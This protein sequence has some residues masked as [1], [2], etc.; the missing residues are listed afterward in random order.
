MDRIGV[1]EF[2]DE[3][4]RKAL[5][6]SGAHHIIG[7]DQG[8][9]A[10]QQIIEIKN[11]GVFLA[12]PVELRD[13]IEGTRHLA[14]HSIANLA[15]QI[16]KPVHTGMEELVCLLAECRPVVFSIR[17]F[18]ATKIARLGERKR[19]PLHGGRARRIGKFPQ[20]GEG[21]FRLETVLVE[22]GERLE[23][24]DQCSGAA[25]LG[26]GCVPT[27]KCADALDK[28]DVLAQREIDRNCAG[29]G[30]RQLELGK[31]EAV[32]DD[33]QR[34]KLRE[35]SDGILPFLQA[36]REAVEQPA[37]D[38]PLEH[39]IRGGCIHHLRSGVEL[40]FDGVGHDDLLTKG[41]NR[42]RGHLVEGVNGR[43]EDI[44]FVVEQF[45]GDG[46]AQDLRNFTRQQLRGV[47]TNTQ[48]QFAGGQ[49]GEGDRRDA[50]RRCSIQHQH[51]DATGNQRCL[52]RARGRL[53]KQRLVEFGENTIAFGG[54]AQHHGSVQSGTSC[55]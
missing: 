23:F 22:V 47:L 34:L 26:V 18:P 39:R 21:R 50:A 2:I 48:R 49:L 1:L 41:V 15:K 9:G 35:G 44:P 5:T 55:C 30:M 14:D 6:D 43:A 37:R 36:V 17:R 11:S 27:S 24:L 10:Q 19:V 4:M 3:D 46:A 52:A 8:M 13:R 20:S 33:L 54:I 12:L 40:R 51:D 53:D 28:V 25:L 42:A 29:A 45:E 16:R 31:V 32:L 7:G 38:D